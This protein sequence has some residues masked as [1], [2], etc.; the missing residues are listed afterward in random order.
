MICARLDH[1]YEMVSLLDYNSRS[2]PKIVEF[3]I[4][5]VYSIYHV[6]SNIDARHC[7]L[8]S[9]GTVLLRHGTPRAVS[10]VP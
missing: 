2:A 3:G 4:R 6:I 7:M 1:I 8:A 10:E 9:F 5:L